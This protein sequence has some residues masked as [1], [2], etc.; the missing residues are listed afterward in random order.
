MLGQ[1]PL[2]SA[3]TASPLREAVKARFHPFAEARG[4]VRA[5]SENPL[6]TQFARSVADE[7]EAFDIQWDKYHRPRFVINFSERRPG[8]GKGTS[9]ALQAQQGGG[10]L[11]RRKGGSQ[12][13]WFQL[14]KPLLEAILSRQW[15]YNPDEVVETVISVFPEVEAWWV[16][17]TVGPHLYFWWAR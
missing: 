11:Q 5:K 1:P 15:T 6:F 14:R 16:D 7:I 10:R 4:F 17:K 8:A 9:S 13:C 3:V 2:T 12:G